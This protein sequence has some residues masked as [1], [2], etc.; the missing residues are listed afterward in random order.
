MLTWT[1]SLLWKFHV[2][3]KF[4]MFF[5][6]FKNVF[7]RVSDVF[8]KFRIFWTRISLNFWLQKF[9]FQNFY[10]LKNILLW[11]W[12]IDFAQT[13]NDVQKCYIYEKTLIFISLDLNLPIFVINFIK[14]DTFLER[15]FHFLWYF[16]WCFIWKH[17]HSIV[18]NVKSWKMNQFSYSLLL[19]H[20]IGPSYHKKVQFFFY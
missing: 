16:P 15:V 18:Q 20:L 17:N 6:Y 12:K 14:Y 3:I 7:Y 13:K 19:Y 8:Y 9:P 10:I 2:A 5:S 1:I 11:H 4:F